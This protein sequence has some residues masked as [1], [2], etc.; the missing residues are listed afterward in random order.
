MIKGFHLLENFV[1]P[2]CKTQQQQLEKDA[3]KKVLQAIVSEIDSEK[4]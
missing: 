3:D 1:L 4:E 2:N